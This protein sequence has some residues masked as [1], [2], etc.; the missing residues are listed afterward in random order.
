MVGLIDI[1]GKGLIFDLATAIFFIVFYSIYLLLVPGRWNRSI[2]NKIITYTAFFLAVFILMFSF[3]AEFTF[4]GEY[5]S[6]F[7]FIAVNYLIYTYEVVNNI[8]ESYPLPLL[9]G[10]MLLLTL[11]TTWLFARRKIFS[12]SFKS[13]TPFRTR[14]KYTGVVLVLATLFYFFLN[15]SWGETRYNRYQNELSK[16]GIWSFFA[17]Y[18]NNEL[19]FYVFYKN[20]GESAAFNMVRTDL[21]GS[22]TKFK[23][24]GNSIRRTIG[25]SGNA[26]KPNVI[27]V[28]IESFSADFMK[29]FGNTKGLTPF[30]DSVADKSIL[31]TNL[32]ATGTRTVRGME[33]LTLGV[34]PTP[35]NSIVRRQDNDSLFNLGTIFRKAGYATGFF[36]G[37]DGFFDNMNAFFGSNGFDITDHGGRLIGEHFKA[38]RTVIPKELIHFENAWG[39]CDEDLYDAV[40]R[41]AD[42]KYSAQQPFFDFVMTTSNHKPYTYPGGKIDIPSGSGRDGAV[43]YTDYAIGEFIKKLQAKPWFNNTVVIFI[44]DHC[45]SSAGKN[46]IDIAKYHIPCIV[47]NLKNTAARTIDNQCSQIDMFPT[48]FGLLHWQYESNWYGK[49]VLLPE[50]QGRI[51]LGTYQELGFLQHDSLVV[52]SPQKK[53]SLNKWDPIKDEQKPI[54]QDSTLL[55]RAIAWYQTAYYLYKN[56]KMKE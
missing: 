42:N 24:E 11:L 45:A 32:Y 30:L 41:D 29:H 13:I 33:A 15:N 43:K 47:Y 37:G 1:Y 3:F 2:F 23:E 5:E 51:C 12:N 46:E 55:H 21:S 34:P 16:A 48:L 53:A 56:G 40:I 8:N 22:D 31:F 36:Y 17:A 20:L 28:T 44:A 39:M 10:G 27:L 38:N 49:N 7:N 54:A 18:K 25:D 9:I 4:W 26:V 35:G 52:L 14:L 19:D 6:R 50:F